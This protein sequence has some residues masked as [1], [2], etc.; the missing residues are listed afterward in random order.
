MKQGF[1][2]WRTREHDSQVLTIAQPDVRYGEGSLGS[3]QCVSPCKGLLY[4]LF[5]QQV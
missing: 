5:T 4:S 2:C 3:M 1:G